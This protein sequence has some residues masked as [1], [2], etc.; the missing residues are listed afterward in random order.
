MDRRLPWVAQLR[1]NPTCGRSWNLVQR[2][3]SRLRVSDG[4]GGLDADVTEALDTAL[5]DAKHEVEY[6][7]HLLRS[8]CVRVACIRSGCA[9]L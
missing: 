5:R 2:R 9:Q 3:V 8:H 4:S 1:L 6:C 7:A